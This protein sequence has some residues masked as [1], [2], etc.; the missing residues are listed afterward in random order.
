VISHGEVHRANL[1]KLHALCVEKGVR[2]GLLLVGG[3]PQVTDELARECGLDAGF[4]RG[5]KGLDVA[6][7]IVRR[8][9]AAAGPQP[10]A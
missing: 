1:S 8:L 6:S 2:A 9:R 3:G 10:E 5:A 7:L 4:G